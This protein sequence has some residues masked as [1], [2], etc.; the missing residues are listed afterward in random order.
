MSICLA[1]HIISI[2]SQQY[3]FLFPMT[4]N[5]KEYIY[6]YASNSELRCS[7]WLPMTALAMLRCGPSLKKLE[8]A[9]E[10]GVSGRSHGSNNRSK[11]LSVNTRRDCG[12]VSLSGKLG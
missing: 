4:M 3:L 5:Y 10:S 1:R 2:R 7:S 9:G 8:F 12:Q 11:W 6:F